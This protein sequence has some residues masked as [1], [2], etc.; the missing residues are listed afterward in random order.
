MYSQD[1]QKPKSAHPRQS[2][3]S[4]TL[5]SFLFFPDLLLLLLRAGVGTIAPD[6]A[7]TLAFTLG[8][9]PGFDKE[10]QFHHCLP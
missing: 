5:F 3:T 2:T 10:L 8:Q 9:A 1:A 6:R 7:L 4:V